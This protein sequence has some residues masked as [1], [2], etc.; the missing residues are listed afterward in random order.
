MPN[1]LGIVLSILAAFQLLFVSL[2]LIFHQR[3]N[4]GNN[5]LLGV[6][7][8]LFAISMTDI[9]IR[10]I[11]ID[12]KVPALHLIDD[13]FI[14]LYGPLIYFY[15]KRVVYRDFQFKILHLIHF[16]P[17]IL[18]ITWLVFGVFSLSHTDQAEAILQIQTASLPMWMVALN[19][20]IY[21][22]LLS[23]LW[24]SNQSIKI[25]SKVIKNNFSSIENINLN[26]LRFIIRSFTAITIVAMIN[27]VVPILGLPFVQYSSLI[28][29][30]IFTFLF[31]NKVLL[32]AL[33]H[34]EIFS[35]ISLKD[36]IKYA[37]SNL[38]SNEIEN[39]KT[40]LVSLLEEEKLYLIPELTIK[41]LADKLSISPKMLS[42]IIN[43]GFNQHFYDFINSYR[44]QEVK[45]ILTN[46]NE[47]ITISEAMYQSGFNS[48]SS[49][50]KEF[51]KLTGQTPSEFKKST[52][53]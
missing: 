29:L 7:F 47:K 41:D 39:Y 48:K 37:G 2:Y 4:K 40:Q 11:G 53:K 42:Q 12:I 32:K 6:F 38:I 46:S 20:P 31:I 28:L 15:T 10:F 43:Q 35:G 44:C 3:G 1:S 50:N 9:A 17:F 26:W 19:L 52:L 18:F 21:L 49:F 51:K 23:Y 8:L 30:L 24:F 45:T 13:G 14:F 33:N 25:Y 36:S 5:K 34:P 27:G 22:Y 16:I